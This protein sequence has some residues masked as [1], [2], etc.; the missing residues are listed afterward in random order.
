MYEL[1]PVDWDID[2]ASFECG[3][4]TRDV[5]KGTMTKKK[6]AA[7]KLKNNCLCLSFL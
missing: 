4:T 6:N 5:F 7:K 1:I 3:I 2:K